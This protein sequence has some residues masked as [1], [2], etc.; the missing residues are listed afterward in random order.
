MNDHEYISYI[1]KDSVILKVFQ[2]HRHE[3]DK[4]NSKEPNG[5]IRNDLKK[6]TSFVL[7]KTAEYF[8]K[9]YLP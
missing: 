2:H 4:F 8:L 6:T 9:K 7:G 1:I 3:I 5:Q